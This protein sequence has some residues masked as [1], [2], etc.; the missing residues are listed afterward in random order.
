LECP[1]CLEF[2]N[3][4][5]HTPRLLCCGHTVCQ[6]CVERLVVSSSLPRFRCPECR[7]LS[8]WRGIHHFPKNYILL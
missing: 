1:V 3:D 4:G 6:L 8:K 5:S 7:A 2:F